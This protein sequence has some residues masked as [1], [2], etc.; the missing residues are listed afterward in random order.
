MTLVFS[1]RSSLIFSI[2]VFVCRPHSMRQYNA[3]AG[4]GG[5]R[6]SARWDNLM[7][8]GI[9]LLFLHL[10]GPK[11]MANPDVEAMA[12][13]PTPLDPPLLAGSLYYN[14]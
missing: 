14:T 6:R 8:P 2:H 11:S 5:S 4:S 3:L 13:F 10:R 7:F 9:S 12:D 1:A